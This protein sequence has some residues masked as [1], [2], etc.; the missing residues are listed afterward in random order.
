MGD[1]KLIV[2]HPGLPDGHI[3]P[4]EVSR[5]NESNQIEPEEKDGKHLD[6]ET[7]NSNR[8]YLFNISGIPY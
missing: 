7:I 6:V 4:E 2:G 5:G 8:I 3:R 1:L